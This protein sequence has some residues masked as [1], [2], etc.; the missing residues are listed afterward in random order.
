MK[1]LKTISCAY[2]KKPTTNKIYCSRLCQ[3]KQTSINK[4]TQRST[5]E[6]NLQKYLRKKYPDINFVFNS[7]ELLKLELDVYIP[8]L[9]IA[10]E[11]N[12]PFHYENIG[13]NLE[14]VQKYDEIKKIKCARRGIELFS[15]DTRKLYRT[16]IGESFYFKLIDRII[17]TK[18]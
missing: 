15:I 14:Q 4:G 16:N 10:F 2:C 13:D 6:I 3:S 17:W 12:G 7:R 9:K 8:K 5:F 18:L 1:N 11:L